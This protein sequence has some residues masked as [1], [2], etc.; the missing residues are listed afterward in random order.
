M[1][2]GPLT[3]KCKSVNKCLA[4]RDV[5]IIVKERE[6]SKNEVESK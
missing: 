1:G 2:E 4:S 3:H 5:K 6:V